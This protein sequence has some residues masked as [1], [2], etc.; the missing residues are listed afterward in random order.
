MLGTLPSYQRR[1]AASL[2]LSWA[3]ELAEEKELTCWVEASPMSVALYKKF[4][5]VIQD[6]IVVQLDGSCG[7]GTQTTSCMMREPRK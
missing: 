4:G 7:G 5:F 2:H 3:I 1:G 6:T